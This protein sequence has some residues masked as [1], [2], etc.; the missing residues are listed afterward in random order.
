VAGSTIAEVATLSLEWEHL[1]HLSGEPRYALLVR[2]AMAAQDTGGAI[3]GAI[4]G[5]VF[6]GYGA[7]A[8]RAAGLMR[9]RGRMWVLWP[10]GEALPASGDSAR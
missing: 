4:R 8:E 10:A 7:E 5:D 6:W 3:T 1:S 2:R 9:S